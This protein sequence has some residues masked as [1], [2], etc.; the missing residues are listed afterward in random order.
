MT[1]RMSSSISWSPGPISLARLLLLAGRLVLTGCAGPYRV[2]LPP[3][4]PA[5]QDERFEVWHQGSRALWRSLQAR[6]DSI[7]GS[8]F[9]QPAGCEPRRA[10]L[11]RA[12]VDS[13]RVYEPFAGKSVFIIAPLGVLMLIVVGLA[14]DRS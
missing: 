2:D 9:P 12:V 1:E 11:T 3:N 13:V 14:T 8:P 7:S 10:S 5:D 6:S 4:P